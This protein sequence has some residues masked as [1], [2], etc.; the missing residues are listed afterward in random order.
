M[1]K[2]CLSSKRWAK[3]S[4]PP[5]KLQAGKTVIDIQLRLQFSRKTA[6][7]LSQQG[8]GKSST[9]KSRQHKISF[10]T[11]SKLVSNG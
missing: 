10:S 9:L 11:A 1:Q 5:A 7:M 3:S 6:P 4:S 2:S 8:M